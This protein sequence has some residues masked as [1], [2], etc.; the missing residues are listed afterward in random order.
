MKVRYFT[1]TGAIE[2]AS[3]QADMAKVAHQQI[4]S[5]SA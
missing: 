4:Q 1:D 2:R 3:K 5:K